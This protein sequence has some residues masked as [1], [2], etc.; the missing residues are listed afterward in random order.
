LE[1]RPALL[2]KGEANLP[3]ASV[4]YVS[5]ILTVDKAKLAESSGK[6]STAAAD[7][8][9]TGCIFYSS[10]CDLAARVSPTFAVGDI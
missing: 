8:C 1:V 6:L 7:A 2:K 9:G 4:V 10:G 3:T 5:Q